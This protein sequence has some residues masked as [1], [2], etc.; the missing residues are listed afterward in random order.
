[1]LMPHH[2][3]DCRLQR[4]LWLAGELGAPYVVK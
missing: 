2:L 3:D 4:I 1:M